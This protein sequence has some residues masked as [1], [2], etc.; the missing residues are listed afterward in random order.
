[1]VIIF[2]VCGTLL[3]LKVRSDEIT[4]RIGTYMLCVALPYCLSQ[5]VLKMKQN[6]NFITNSNGPCMFSYIFPGLVALFSGIGILL[7][8][9]TFAMFVNPQI[10]SIFIGRMDIILSYHAIIVIMSV[11]ITTAL[12][13]LLIMYEQTK[14]KNVSHSLSSLTCIKFTST[15]R[16]LLLA[17]LTMCFALM[18][19]ASNGNVFFTKHCL[20]QHTTVYQR[21]ASVYGDSNRSTDNSFSVLSWN[22]LLGHD[23][24]GRDN[25]PCV[26]K[27]LALFKPDV[28]GLEESDALPL[29]WGG[30]DI[31]YY[32]SHYLGIQS[33]PGVH[34]LLSSLGVGI[35]TAR[36]VTSHHSY[37][38]P[39]EDDEK[40]P[41]YSLI[42][43]DCELNNHSLTV[44]NVHAVFKNW[45]ATPNNRCPY[46]NLSAKQVDF[47]AKQVKNI[48]KQQPVII[49][50]DFN[51]NPNEPQLDVLYNMGF[52]N[53][54]HKNRDLHP[55]STLTTRF[56][57]IDHIFYRGLNLTSSRT[58]VETDGI[59]DHF[60]VMAYFQLPTEV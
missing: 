4:P 35:L 16:P 7:S 56:A 11:I 21:I 36:N 32:L 22:I 40:L 33:Y 19:I 17:M 25:L 38:L 14:R 45:T 9:L 42:R 44:F 47:I 50:G 60:P 23:I 57:I 2:L 53:A 6:I 58:I 15:P 26:G 41:H 51:L 10:S 46:A 34:P 28:I 43:V 49:M 39:V 31:L 37:L 8:H 3:L 48:D 30:K 1:M 55:P 24:Y 5:N 12:G 52:K 18:G 59:S 20:Q 54:L 27:V 13:K 29:Y